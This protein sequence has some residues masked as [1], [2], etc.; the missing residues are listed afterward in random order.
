MSYLLGEP[1]HDKV[2]IPDNE[3]KAFEMFLKSAQKGFED[4]V[5][6]VADCY[7]EG[8]GVEKSILYS[9]ACYNIA[10]LRTDLE[11]KGTKLLK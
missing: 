1:W 8:R 3:T 10:L 11:F 5:E 9:L 2:L 6:D 4:G 7:E